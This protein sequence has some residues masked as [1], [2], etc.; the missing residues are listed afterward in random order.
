MC[1]RN[2]R[3]NDEIT[4]AETRADGAAAR[5]ERICSHYSTGS[6]K[7]KR[8]KQRNFDRFFGETSS[9]K[10]SIFYKKA[11]GNSRSW[12]N[13]GKNREQPK[14]SQKK[15]PPRFAA[16]NCAV[17]RGGCLCPLAGCDRSGYI[18]FRGILGV[19]LRP[20]AGCNATQARRLWLVFTIILRPLA[21]CNLKKQPPMF[22]IRRYYPTSPCGV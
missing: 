7:E 12:K 5:H 14:I 4:G 19:I 15:Q 2:S 13:C 8:R 18:V 11:R 10:Q 1:Q 22:V 20:L 3:K 21:G 17:K 9:G 16:Q 6:D